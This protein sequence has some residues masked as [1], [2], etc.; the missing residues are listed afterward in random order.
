M[1]RRGPAP[2][3][4]KLKIASGNPGKRPLN[5]GEPCPPVAVPTMPEWLSIGAKEEWSR[6][7]LILEER[8]TLTLGDR[9]IV[10]DFCQA[11]HELA[12]ATTV[13]D[14]EDRIVREPIQTASGEI[15]GYKL[16][17]HP[18][19]RIQHDAMTRVM[20]LGARLGLSPADRTRVSTGDTTGGKH[21][22]TRGAKFFGS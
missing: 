20:Q 6:V 15:V 4:V 21:E 3:P 16:K 11:V 14:S 5:L 19:V 1:G 8:G 17:A 18:M 9:D 13:L 2:K 10:A 22:D 12:N 7:V